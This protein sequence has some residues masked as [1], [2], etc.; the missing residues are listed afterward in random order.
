MSILEKFKNFVAPVESGSVA[1]SDLKFTNNKKSIINAVFQSLE[2]GT[3]LGVY[4]N[5]FGQG[6][7]LVAVEKFY[8]EDEIVFYKYDATGLLLLKNVVS[9]N[10]IKTVCPFADMYSHP[11]IQRKAS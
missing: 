2:N 8:S 3:V 9:I 4:C 11:I 6:M 1:L 10:E 7:F 5:A